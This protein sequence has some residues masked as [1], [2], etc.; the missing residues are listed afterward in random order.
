MSYVP[1][2]VPMSGSRSLPSSWNLGSLAHTFCANSNCLI[3]LAQPT[4]AAMPR[5]TPSSGRALRQ[6]RPVGPAAADDAAAIH[7]HGRIARVHAPDVGAE[8]DRV[9]V[10]V[11][12]SVIEVVVALRVRRKLGVVL[13]GR[14][15]ERCA[16]A[17]SPH[18]L[19]RD[20]FLLLRRGAVRSQ[21]VAECADVLFDPAIGEKAA[22]ARQDLGLRATDP[23]SPFSSGYPR[24]NSPG[25][26]GA[27]VPGVGSI[28]MPSIAGCDRR[29]R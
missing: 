7:V 22:V 4:K 24:K 16:A 17:P 9:A 11:H 19:R 12:L 25:L 15:H 21:E 3:R 26:S 23:V 10:R 8:R 20:Q 27:P 2:C 14:E 28:P 5:S 29:S 1:S 18:Q 13:R 6:R